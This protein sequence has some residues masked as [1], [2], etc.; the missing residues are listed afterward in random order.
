GF[1]FPSSNI[2]D[3]IGAVYDYGPYGSELKKNIRDFWWNAMTRGTQR[4]VGLDAAILMHP[5][6]WKASGHLDHFN[7][8]MIDN[9]DSKKRYRVYHLF[10]QH[11]AT[12]AE[13]Q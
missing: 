7:D 10:E 4:I 11:A 12:L 6:V 3:G 8:P 2:Y 5:Q 9:K 13:P 1:I